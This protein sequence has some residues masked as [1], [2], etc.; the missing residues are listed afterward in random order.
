MSTNEQIY[1][2]RPE[3]GSQPGPESNDAKNRMKVT[4][5][6]I[7]GYDWDVSGDGRLSVYAWRSSIRTRVASYEPGRW[8]AVQR[9]RNL[10]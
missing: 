5:D 4:Y 3:G 10:R 8:L 9:A 1:V 7:L 6:V 2:D